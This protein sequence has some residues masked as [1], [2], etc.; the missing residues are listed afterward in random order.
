MNI[1]LFYKQR[2]WLF[3]GPVIILSLV[4]L[5]WSWHAFRPLPPTQVVIAAGVPGG[6]YSLLAQEYRKRLDALGVEAVLLTVDKAHSAKDLLTH[7][8]GAQLALANSLAIRRTATSTAT[9]QTPTS[10]SVHPSYEALAAIEREPIWVFSRQPAG[11]KLPSLK[12]LRVGVPARD[13][14]QQRVLSIVL[15]QAQLS[16]KDI[17]VVPLARDVIAN[18]LQDGKV[19]ALVLMGSVRNDVIRLLLRS[20][21][22]QLVGMDSVGSLLNREPMLR[23]FVLPQGAIELRGEVPARDLTMVAGQLYLI[24]QPDMHPALQRVILQAASQIHEIPNFL[25]MQGEFPSFTGLDIPLSAAATAYSRGQQPWL[26][27]LLPYR[28]AQFMEWLLM[29]AIPIVLLSAWVF[30]RIPALFEWRVEAALQHF[31]GE[32]KFIETDI[33][34]SITGRPLGVDRL[35]AQLDGLE[36]QVMQLELPALHADRWYTLRHHLV[37]ARERAMSLR[38]R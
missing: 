21:G 23:P 34:P 26:E 11:D 31:Y 1:H 37:S 36:R 4:A 30:A 16:Q 20:E 3:Y 27:Q 32:L 13:E 17:T 24:A 35:L 2:L 10:A 6:G 8:S 7:E 12:G 28:W 14:L 29:A 5:L 18:E 9:S 22:I 19:D 38:A 25:Q 33:E 15:T